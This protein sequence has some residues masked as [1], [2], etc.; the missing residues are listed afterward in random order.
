MAMAKFCLHTMPPI[1]R[2]A[3]AA[4][5]PTLRGESIVLDVGAT[6]GADAQHLVDLAIMGAAMARIVFDIDSPTVGLLNVGVEEIKGVEEVKAAGRVLREAKL[7]NMRYHGFVE[8]DDLGKGTVDVFVTEGFTGNIALK[9][10]EGTAKQIGQYI[11]DAMGSSLACRASAPYSRARALEALRAKMDPRANGGVFLG[12][13][14]VVIKSHGGADAESFAGA[15]ELGYDMVRQELLGKIRE[16]IGHAN[17]FR[18]AP[19][20]SRR[21]PILT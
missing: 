1:E 11:R 15:V 19:A 20:H 5:W 2:P 8:G 4:M 17:G 7:P 13:D 21:R 16:M 6:I 14:G 18:P 3:I 9:T 12:L 10:A